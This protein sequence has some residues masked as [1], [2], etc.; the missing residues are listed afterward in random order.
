MQR[1]LMQ[2]REKSVD[3]QDHD[4]DGDGKRREFAPRA[5]FPRSRL[6]QRS[7]R[8]RQRLGWLRQCPG[9]LSNGLRYGRPVSRAR[10]LNRA[11]LRLE[12]AELGAVLHGRRFGNRFK[13]AGQEIAA[14]HKRPAP[15]TALLGQPARGL[16]PEGRLGF[17]I[18][19]N[20]KV[21]RRPI[22]DITP[23]SHQ[24]NPALHFDQGSS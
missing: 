14:R 22:E 6:R 1:T 8:L 19:I 17:L 23:L 24:N 20:G 18:E 5:A 7:R 16:L 3:R 13:L 10:S 11:G 21:T 15:R 4:P 2:E 12:M 9:R